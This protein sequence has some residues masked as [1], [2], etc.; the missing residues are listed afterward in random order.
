MTN[1][2]GQYQSYSLFIYAKLPEGKSGTAQL[3]LRKIVDGQGTSNTLMSP[4]EIN[5]N[6]WTRLSA[7]YTHSEMDNNSFF[8]VKGPPVTG[9]D[10][11]D[12]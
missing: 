10:G 1:I 9:S 7:D 8:F 6:D 11:I 3:M 5:S 4:V 2:F 12:Y